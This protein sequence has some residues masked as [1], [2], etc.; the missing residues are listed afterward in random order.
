MCEYDLAS[1][2][3][4][5]GVYKKDI[6]AKPKTGTLQIL[7]EAILNYPEDEAFELVKQI[8]SC[9]NLEDVATEV[10]GQSDLIDKEVNDEAVSLV[11]S[12]SLST[13]IERELASQIGHMR[14]ADGAIHFVGG[15][16]NLRFSQNDE[17]KF[18]DGKQEE[19]FTYDRNEDIIR[20]WTTVTTDVDLILHLLQLYFTWHYPSFVTL[21]K[22]LF[23]RDFFRGRPVG[24]VERIEYCTPLLVNSMLSLGCHFTLRSGARSDVEDKATAGDH[25]FKEAKRLLSDDEEFE[26][27]RLST[28]QALALMSVR[29]AGCGREAKGWLYSGM[30]F[31][32]AYDLGLEM[33]LNMDNKT[34]NLSDEDIDA[35]R[36]TFWG[37]YQFDKYEL[38]S[39]LCSCIC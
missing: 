8:R 16:S 18:M 38:L 20:S 22:P 5:K 34:S 7:I 23:F 37:C 30:S 3:R 26:I 2:H 6:N 1:D 33:Q 31:R 12:A 24:P 25:F 35:R 4:R 27:P 32:M 15:T 28:I 36:I 14:L 17:N 10:Q 13:N 11:E 9:E 19:I 21:S 39:L 29:E